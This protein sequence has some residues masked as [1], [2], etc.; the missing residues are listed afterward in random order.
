[1]KSLFS[2]QFL[3]GIFVI[4]LVYFSVSIPSPAYA[5]SNC[6]SPFSISADLT[7]YYKGHGAKITIIDPIVAASPMTQETILVKVTSTRDPVG[8]INLVFKENGTDTCTFVLP[9]SST[10]PYTPGYVM[11]LSATDPGDPNILP[12]TFSNM[13]KPSLNVDITDTVTIQATNGTTGSITRSIVADDTAT[14]SITTSTTNQPYKRIIKSCA[15]EGGDSD[16]DGLCNNWETASGLT[17][18][19]TRNSVTAT[20]RYGNTD[21]TCKKQIDDPV[22]GSFGVAKCPDPNKKDIFVEADFL[23]RHYPN[24]NDLLQVVQAFDNAGINLHILIDENL[25]KHRDNLSIPS[26]GEANPPVTDFDKL[27]TNNFGT[28]GERSTTSVPAPSTCTAVGSDCVK[29]L[30]T[31]KR[32]AFHWAL[33]G[34]FNTANPASSGSAELP[35]NDIFVTLG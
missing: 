7:Q 5:P 30:L 20:Y 17:I 13:Q 9:T 23:K 27:K 29:N 2:E 18:S 15:S 4:A 11:F 32:Q 28:P 22:R 14:W 3:I 33:Y 12:G 19:Y 35:G 31:A 8:L 34:H 16:G 10:P 21:G 25:Q 1:M 6:G 26:A 24:G